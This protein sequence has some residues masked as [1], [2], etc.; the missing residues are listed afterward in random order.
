M[1]TFH[2]DKKNIVSN[3][4][5]ITGQDA[6]HLTNVLRLKP[7]TIV[8]LADGQGTKYTAKILNISSKQVEL[9][10]IKKSFLESE[11]PVHI[12]IAQGILKDK[13]MD[14]LIRHL[15]ELGVS[16]WIPFF[17]KRTI[18]TPS[19][20]KIQKRIQRWEKI[21]KEA[22]KQCGRSLV[23]II[24]QP[25]EFNDLLKKYQDYDEKIAFWE[26][27][28]CPIDTIKE[29]D[30]DNNDKKKIII[31]IGPEGGFSEEEIENAQKK[32]FNSFSLGPRILRAETASIT[33]CALIQNIFGDLGKKT[34]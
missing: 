34:S 12:C 19:V 13:K 30:K 24:E 17:A 23:P 33:S 28:S 25:L 8:E 3:I 1:H 14:M 11:S 22:L 31:L 15:T 7:N 5:Q 10:I 21:A 9:K 27:A 16:E 29:H 4:A 26:N 6:K 32:G 18:P 2:I 20:Q